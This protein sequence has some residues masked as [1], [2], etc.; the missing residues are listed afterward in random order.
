[1]EK[2][3]E[4]GRETFLRRVGIAGES[5]ERETIGDRPG[6]IAD[7]RVRRDATFREPRR[8]LQ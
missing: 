1:M 3:S 8:K 7:F 6:R 5:P 4:R 2:L